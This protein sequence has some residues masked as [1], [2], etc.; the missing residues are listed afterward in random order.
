MLMDEEESAMK[1]LSTPDDSDLKITR[2]EHPSC[3][4]K[5]SILRVAANLLS[6][7]CPRLSWGALNDLTRAACMAF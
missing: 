1:C 2:S 3:N 7:G 6:I 4:G 5:E